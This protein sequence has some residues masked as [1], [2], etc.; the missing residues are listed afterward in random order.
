MCQEYESGLS[1]GLYENCIVNVEGN[2][3]WIPTALDVFFLIFFVL[4]QQDI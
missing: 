4:S 1:F 3:N 2:T